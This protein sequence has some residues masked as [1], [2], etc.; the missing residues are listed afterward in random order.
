MTSGPEAL[1]PSLSLPYN[2]AAART[3]TAHPPVD[4][5]ICSGSFRPT[6]QLTQVRCGHAFHICMQR[7]RCNPPENFC[8]TCYSN[9]YDGEDSACT[10]G[11]AE[12]TEHRFKLLFSSFKNHSARG[13]NCPTC[14][15]AISSVGSEGLNRAYVLEGFVHDRGDSSFC[16]RAR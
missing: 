7:L 16:L 11:D 6:E 15:Q 10:H 4:C 1:K 12:D 9:H 8:E 14:R 5:A 2:L 3:P 13:L